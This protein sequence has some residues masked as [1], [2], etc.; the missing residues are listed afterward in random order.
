LS[1][2]ARLVWLDRAKGLAMLLVVLGH[3]VA[4]EPPTG[5]A[6]YVWL[7]AA[8]YQFH[9]PFF[10]ALS[11]FTVFLT[12]AAVAPP[13]GWARLWRDRSFRL[14]LPYAAFGLLLLGAKLAAQPFLHVDNPIDRDVGAA[15]RDLFWTT[16]R[17]PATSIWY[18][19]VL[20]WYAVLTPVLLWL[21]R[22][23]VLV[24]LGLA[25]V[26]YW[27]GLPPFAFADRIAKFY[28]FFVLGGLLAEHQKRALGAIDRFGWLA[29]PCFLAVLVLLPHRAYGLGFT[30]AGLL[31]LPALIWLCRLPVLAGETLLP[32]IGGWSFVIYLFNTLAI[33][34]TKAVLLKLMPWHGAN[35]LVF[36]PVLM[37]AGTLGPILLREFVLVRV[38]P[39]Y[40]LT[41]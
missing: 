29:W 27:V 38:P 12:G 35:F 26:L 7:K 30:L 33:G 6:W 40:R 8:I 25:A 39:L 41:R 4:R 24:L 1:A 21:L 5:N 32:R 19:F 9:M 23:Q 15:L 10:M 2:R 28:V 13:S 17:S 11:G 18:I 34:F 20:F 37:L 14:L 3:L 22:G 16:S 36:A 31:S